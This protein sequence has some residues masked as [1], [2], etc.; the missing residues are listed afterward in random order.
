[1][2]NDF[3]KQHPKAKHVV[4]VGLILA[5]T[6]GL[7]GCS[8]VQQTGPSQEELSKMEETLGPDMVQKYTGNIWF[9]VEIPNMVELQK[10]NEPYYKNLPDDIKK[11]VQDRN[12]KINDEIIKYGFNHPV[13]IEE[14]IAQAKLYVA[15]TAEHIKLHD[16]K[17]DDPE[18]QK[19]LNQA[20]DDVLKTILDTKTQE[21][22]ENEKIPDTITWDAWKVQQALLQKLPGTNLDIYHGTG[23]FVMQ[24]QN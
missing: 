16:G 23:L 24:Q 10:A 15:R 12:Q 17:L 13:G 19:K 11:T 20:T 2:L 6:L 5:T 4:G 9:V 8:T 22:N 21:K 14:A 3:L 7:A 18:S 1:M